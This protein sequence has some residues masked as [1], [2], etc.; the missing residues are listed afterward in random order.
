M[1]YDTYYFSWLRWRGVTHIYVGCTQSPTQ[2]DTNPSPL[3]HLSI[4]LTFVKLQAIKLQD[5]TLSTFLTHF[6]HIGKLMASINRICEEILGIFLEAKGGCLDVLREQHAN[7]FGASGQKLLH[8]CFRI[9][10]VFL[11]TELQMNI[12]CNFSFPKEDIFDTDSKVEKKKQYFERKSNKHRIR[13]STHHLIVVNFWN[14]PNHCVYNNVWRAV[15]V[16]R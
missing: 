14:G 2:A 16:R 11:H 7:T 12:R 15:S 8:H 13:S 6:L 9:Y 3:H 5:K 4:N 10:C 1:A